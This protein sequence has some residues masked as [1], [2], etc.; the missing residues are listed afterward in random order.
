MFSVMLLQKLQQQQQQQQQS[1]KGSPLL[2]NEV[3]AD[4]LSG[5]QNSTD[6]RQ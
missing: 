3:Q 5:H 1:L 2:Q 6:S 4:W